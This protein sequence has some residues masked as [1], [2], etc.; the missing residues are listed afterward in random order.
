MPDAGGPD[1]SGDRSM[2]LPA[3]PLHRGCRRDSREPRAAPSTPGAPAVRWPTTPGVGGPGP[4]GLAVPDL[5]GLAVEP[6]HHPTGHRPRLAPPRVPVLLA[7]EV[8]REPRR[9]PAP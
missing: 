9:P 5:G 4:L 1:D 3:R 6:G 8:E 2:D 7:V